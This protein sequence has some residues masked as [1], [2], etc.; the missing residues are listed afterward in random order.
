VDRVLARNGGAA[1]RSALVAQVGR[2]VFDHEV[3]RGELIAIF[4]RVYSR[5]WLVDDPTIQ[6]I[7][8]VRSCGSPS[9]LSHTTALAR[10]GLVGARLSR[11]IHVTS[12]ALRH[13]RGVP[14]RLVVH[15]SRSP[16]VRSLDTGLPT[17]GLA[18]ALV[19]SWPLLRGAEQRA[20]LI[21]ASRQRSVLLAD[22]DAQLG[23]YPKLAGRA[24]LAEL[25]RLLGAGCE[26]ELELWGYQAVFNRPEFQHGRWQLPVRTRHGSFR[27]DL[28]FE[29]EKLAVELD[30]RTYHA[31]AEHWERDIR[32][33]L[34]LATLG[35]QTVRLSHA[36]LTS[37]VAGCRRDIAAVLR[38]RRASR[39]LSR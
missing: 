14:D 3:R 1:T 4:R 36:R 37:D 20:P 8:A 23:A 28:A 16:F 9:L 15:R 17:I 26:S 31:A 29:A 13:P 11:P 24:R 12:Y 5:P 21:R 32:R 33:D 27:I 34:E 35:W 22:V 6:Q 2:A 10:F 38:S 19:Q 30:G 7:A 25:L 39:P 18:E